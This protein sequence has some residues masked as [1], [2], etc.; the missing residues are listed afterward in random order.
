MQ[1][2]SN[3]RIIGITGGTGSGKSTMA[4][5][6][7]EKYSNKISIIH[8]DDYFKVDSKED[9]PK[10]D[11]MIM[12]DHPRAIDFEKLKEHLAIVKK[13]NSF[14]WITKHYSK[15]T[16]QKTEIN[17]VTKRIPYTFYSKEIVILEGF[18]TAFDSEIRDQLDFL[19]YLDAPED[20]RLSRRQWFADEKYFSLILKPMQEKYIYPAKE[21]ADV[22]LEGSK[23]EVFSEIESI[24]IE[25]EIL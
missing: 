1:K 5:M 2:G 24:L 23:E 9:I 10:Y 11:G 4:E 6:L 16:H 13:G 20:V 8:L 3:M 25:K 19:I 7:E 22:I 12:W 21:N 17:D 15:E 18:L 14:K